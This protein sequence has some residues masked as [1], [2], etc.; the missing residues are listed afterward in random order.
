MRGLEA[1]RGSTLGLAAAA[2]LV[3]LGPIASLLR[4]HNGLISLLIAGLAYQAGNSFQ[5][6]SLSM[7]APS[8]FVIL[9]CSALAMLL[10]DVGALWWFVGIG[11][12]SWSLQAIRRRF[13]AAPGD[14]LPS[15]AQKRA[16]RILGFVLATILPPILWVPAVWLISLRSLARRSSI[17]IPRQ[18]KVPTRWGNSLEVIMVL[19]QSHYFSYCYALPLLL[20]ESALGGI[21][22]VGTW[23]AC[24]WVSYLLAENAWRRFAP[25][26]TFLVGH[27]CLAALLVAMFVFSNFPWLVAALWI[28][29][30]LGGGTVYCLTVLHQAEGWPHQ[31]LEVAEDFGHVLGVLISLILVI[32]AGWKGDAL[33]ALGAVWATSAVAAML[34]L[35]FVRR[36]ADA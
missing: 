9:T 26:H 30:G 13:V 7:G 24:G 28:L 3:E 17:E 35:I 2:S 12:F 11:T 23:F 18:P 31:R 10:I 19:H 1:R 33:P 20:A 6:I 36:S 22:F 25:T 8:L 5:R 34:Y 4:A 29:S 14:D 32:V 15:T 27:A 21:P 16:A